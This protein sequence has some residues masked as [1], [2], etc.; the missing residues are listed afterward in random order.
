MERRKYPDGEPRIV[1]EGKE[2]KS[3]RLHNSNLF[4]EGE[5]SSGQKIDEATGKAVNPT[6]VTAVQM[7]RLTV[8][9][10]PFTNLDE[11]DE[12]DRWLRENDPEYGKKETE[13]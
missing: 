1:A 7:D 5:D 12:A 6:E 4:D 10:K 2:L 9:R 3:L 8:T 13:E 11:H